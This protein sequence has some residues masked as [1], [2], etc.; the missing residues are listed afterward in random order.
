MAGG[1]YY[2][3]FCLRENTLVMML[4][5]A[6]GHGVKACMSIMTDAH[7]DRHDPQPDL[8]GHR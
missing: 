8:L 2:D 5:D 6:A 3:A 7:A 4:G 1:D